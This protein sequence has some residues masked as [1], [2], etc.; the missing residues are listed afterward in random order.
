MPG[1][2]LDELKPYSL[3]RNFYNQIVKPLYESENFET[4]S[5]NALKTLLKE[6]IHGP[7]WRAAGP[8]AF[9]NALAGKV[10]EVVD[11]YRQAVVKENH[12]Q[13]GALAGIGGDTVVTKQGDEGPEI[14]K[15][16]QFKTVGAEK[17]SGVHENIQKAAWQLC[18]L[19]GETP[20]NGSRKVIEIVL[21]GTFAYTAYTP[22]QWVEEIKEALNEGYNQSG[23]GASPDKLYANVDF[24]KITTR[25]KRYKF[26]VSTNPNNV[27]FKSEK[28]TPKHFIFETSAFKVHWEW[29]RAT[30]WAQNVANLEGKDA[31][32]K[33]THDK[34]IGVEGAYPK[35]PFQPGPGA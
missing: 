27:V 7:F 11:A 20:A 34:G 26:Q 24:V 35:L 14:V 12:A 29:L 31:V 6:D 8:P 30:W 17:I 25:T 9:D 23:K 5:Q 10:Q 4:K 21:Y 28:D 32:V 22:E 15:T 1:V 18:G 19:G 3:S 33:K 2:T 16:S 13:L